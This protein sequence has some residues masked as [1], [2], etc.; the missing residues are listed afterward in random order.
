MIVRAIYRTGPNTYE[1][2]VCKVVEG[3]CYRLRRWLLF[4]A[5]LDKSRFALVDLDHVFK[6]NGRT[7]VLIDSETNS[8]VPLPRTGSDPVRAL[9]R[10]LAVKVVSNYMI[11]NQLEEERRRLQAYINRSQLFIL[12]SFAGALA[13]GALAMY[14]S[15]QM[16]GEAV[17]SA[18]EAIL[19]AP[20]VGG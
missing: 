7:Y 8:S 13:F 20:E 15:Q 16:V 14:F 5:R 19:P 6:L 2:V 12:I 10:E 4:F 1:S 17:R 18:V 3:K 11:M 9:E